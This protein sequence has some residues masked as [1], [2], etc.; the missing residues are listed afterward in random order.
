MIEGQKAV[1]SYMTGTNGYLE[2][3]N[4]KEQKVAEADTEEAKATRLEAY[5]GAVADMETV[6]ANFNTEI[7]KWKAQPAK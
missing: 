5:N 4:Q 7:K 3:L 2:C 6:A 1:K